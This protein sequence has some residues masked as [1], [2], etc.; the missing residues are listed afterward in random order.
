M[1]GVP[2]ANNKVLVSGKMAVAAASRGATLLVRSPAYGLVVAGSGALERAMRAGSGDWIYVAYVSQEER[3]ELELCPYC[4]RERKRAGDYLP[5]TCGRS[6]CQ[7]ADFHDCRIRS[8]R[9]KRERISRGDCPRPPIG[10][11]CR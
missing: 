9:N 6:E 11:L 8:S 5:P 1:V 10:L 3:A 4:Y 2:M 7:E